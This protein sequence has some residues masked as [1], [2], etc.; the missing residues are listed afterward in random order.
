MGKENAFKKISKTY[1]KHIYKNIAYCDR[2]W[3]ENNMYLIRN[4]DETIL[5]KLKQQLQQQIAYKT[6]ILNWG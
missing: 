5:I 1:N 6:L 3:N 2:I 4:P